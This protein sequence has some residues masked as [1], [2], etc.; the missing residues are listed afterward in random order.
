[1]DTNAH[2]KS[3]TLALAEPDS[4]THADGYPYA[5][6]DRLTEPVAVTGA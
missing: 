6:A 4:V 1:M 2:A 3:I 5:F